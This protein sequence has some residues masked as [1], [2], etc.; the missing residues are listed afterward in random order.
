LAWGYYWKI[1]QY[2][3]AAELYKVSLGLGKHANISQARA[4]NNIANIHF[5]KGDMQKASQMFYEAYRRY[6]NYYLFKLN[7]AKVKVKTGEW[8]TALSL[9]DQILSRVPDYR[10]ALSLKGQVLL[11]Q[12]RFAD[13]VDSYARLLKQKSDDPVAML[14]A[15]IGL[16][17]MGNPVRAEWY[18]KAAL[19]NNP[20]SG[21]TLLWLI[22][23]NLQLENLEA[24]DKYMDILLERFSFNPLISEINDIRDDNLMP[25]SSQTRII[26]DLTRKLKAKSAEIAKLDDL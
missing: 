24:A 26:Q 16:R 18:F 25:A 2:D 19:R 17:L 21:S 3:K 13:A 10:P 1:G 9:L 12:R 14:N 7:L 4:I 23:T 6:P 8:Q 22:E 20:R 15:G 5:I 11:K